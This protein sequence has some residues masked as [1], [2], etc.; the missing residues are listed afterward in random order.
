MSSVGEKHIA[1]ERNPKISKEECEMVISA[2]RRMVFIA[3]RRH[4][5][6]VTCVLLT[7]VYYQQCVV[8]RIVHRASVIQKVKQMVLL[9]T[10]RYIEDVMAIQ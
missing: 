8:L 2:R 4:V 3:G 9:F 5:A 6:I 1:R 7:P 10:E